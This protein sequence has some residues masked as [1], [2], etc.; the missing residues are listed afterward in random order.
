NI[1]E[2]RI[3]KVLTKI[4]QT[5]GIEG[6]NV[7]IL[8]PYRTQLKQLEIEFGIRKEGRSKESLDSPGATESEQFTGA[9]RLVQEYSGI[10]VHTIDRYQG[11]DAD[12]IIIS[13]VRSNNNQAI[14][15]LLR[16]WR[17]INVA[18]T[19]ARFKLI[20]VGSRNTLTRSPLLGGMIGILNTRGCVIG[21]PANADIPATTSNSV[22]ISSSTSASSDSSTTSSQTKQN[23]SRSTAGSALLKKHPISAN[24]IAE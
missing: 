5:C 15:D 1:A 20:V 19:R 18:I 9:K 11:R 13:L 21:I 8:S 23:G 10:E 17:R 2:I 24:I 12:V 16:D 6:R 22:T 3:I 14:G 4:L 7:G